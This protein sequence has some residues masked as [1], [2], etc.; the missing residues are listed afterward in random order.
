MSLIAVSGMR[1]FMPVLVNFVRALSAQ[2]KVIFGAFYAMIV[3]VR[4]RMAKTTS[5]S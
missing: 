4:N 2:I 1:H 5:S 3:V